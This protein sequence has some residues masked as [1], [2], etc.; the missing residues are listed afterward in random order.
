[1]QKRTNHKKLQGSSSMLIIMIVVILIFFGVLSVLSAYSSYKLSQRSAVYLNSSYALESVAH[2]CKAYSVHNM[3]ESAQ[4]AI[5]RGHEKKEEPFDNRKLYIEELTKRL[6]KLQPPDLKNA[7]LSQTEDGSLQWNVI[8]AK[9]QEF[10]IEEFNFLLV[11]L[12]PPKTLS[13]AEE[14]L[15]EVKSWKKLPRD[16]GKEEYMEFED[17]TIKTTEGEKP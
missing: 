8:I 16:M 15:F 2:E 17:I 1:M 5:D 7:S 12:Y 13:R 4:K 10:G 11:F 9:E 14:A 3:Y 6:S